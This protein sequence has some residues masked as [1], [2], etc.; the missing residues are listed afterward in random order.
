MKTTVRFNLLDKAGILYFVKVESRVQVSWTGK[1]VMG[2][3]CL[4]S[5]EF[6]FGM[7]NSNGSTTA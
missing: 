2:Y 3:Y 7:I 6:H 5:T 1:G 4:M